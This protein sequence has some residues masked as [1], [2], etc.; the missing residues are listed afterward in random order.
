MLNVAQSDFSEAGHLAV[1]PFVK[2]APLGEALHEGAYAVD[3]H[4]AT[5]H[6]QE[7]YL[8]GTVA[9]T[10]R[11]GRVIEAE[12][13]AWA[14]HDEPTAMLATSAQGEALQMAIVFLLKRCYPSVIMPGLTS[15]ELCNM[16]ISAQE[17]QGWRIVN[18]Y[19]V[20]Y[21]SGGRGARIEQKLMTFVEL[22][23]ELSDDDRVLESTR[24]ACFD[25]EG[26][27]A[28]EAYLS[29]NGIAKVYE[30]D[31]NLFGRLFVEPVRQRNVEK[32]HVMSDRNKSGQVPHGRPFTI[33]FDTSLLT[34]R[35]ELER[36]C[37]VLSRMRDASIT[38]FH[39]NPHLHLAVLDYADA[40]TLDICMTGPGSLRVIPSHRTSEASLLRVCN[41]ILTRYEEGTILG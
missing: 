33:E 19:S 32:Y 5:I 36:L 34:E 40:S 31:L 14:H 35:S 13:T 41:T 12:F 4:T 20:A 7:E 8:R 1:I 23:Q 11:S 17:T 9:R 22:V 28:M 24:F 2:R 21:P 6:G 15:R 38:V 26:R 27:V 37:D 30:G 16:I 25:A 29:R 3:I 18:K 10:L 39:L